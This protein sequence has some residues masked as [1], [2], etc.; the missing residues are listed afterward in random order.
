M[1]IVSNTFSSGQIIT[2]TELNEN[3]TDLEAYLTGI[4]DAD[5]SPDAGIT[6]RKLLDRY[7]PSFVTLPL[8]PI[9]SAAA[10]ATGAGFWTLPDVAGAASAFVLTRFYPEFRAGRR[11]YLVAVS[12][13]AVEFDA[14]NAR[15]PVVFIFQNT[16]NLAGSA[17][18]NMTNTGPWYLKN[19]DPYGAPIAIFDGGTTPGDYVEIRIAKSTTGGACLLR[20]LTAVLTFKNEVTS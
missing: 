12:L 5:I 13:Y 9:S 7:A 18:I 4:R 2:H 20:G 6:S 8:L 17:G 19:S 11:C 14:A 1:P 3:F 16:T 15:T 10:L